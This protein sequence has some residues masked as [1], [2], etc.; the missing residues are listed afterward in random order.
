MTRA[1]PPI[2]IR[3]GAQMREYGAMVARIASD[4]PGHVLDWG[5]G[6]GQVTRL[7]ADAGLRVTALDYRPEI[8]REG[9]H[10]QPLFPDV[11]VYVTHDPVRLPFADGTYDAVLSA[12][13]LEHVEHPDRSLDEIRRVLVPGGRLY[14]YKLPNRFSYVEKLLKLLG[15]PH[16]GNHGPY[17]VLYTRP[18][19]Y[20]LLERHGFRVVEFRRANV[21]PLLRV[22]ARVPRA[23]PALWAL[24]RALSRVPGLNLVATNLELVAESARSSPGLR[25]DD[26]PRDRVPQERGVDRAA[27]DDDVSGRVAALEVD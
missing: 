22:G 24:N 2:N 5:A 13:V 25:G 18:S 3:S 26:D 10:E 20:R 19:A 6:F 21:L 4:R 12:G 9:Y 23:A 11:Q 16:H 8:E 14:I 15:L 1:A 27:A 7:L 17:D